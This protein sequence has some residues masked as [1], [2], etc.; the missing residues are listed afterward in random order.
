MQDT[1]NP[2]VRLKTTFGDM[3]ISLY[4]Q[5][6]PETVANFLRYVKEGFYDGTIFH[7]VIPG[8][9]N[10]GGGFKPGMKEKETFEA[11]RNEADNGLRNETGTIAMARTSEPHSATSQFFINA[12][13]ND[14]LDYKSPSE[15]GWGY[16]VFGKIIDGE[17]VH[18]AINKVSTGS[19]KGYDDVPVNDV[20]LE[21]AEVLD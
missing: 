11:I 21:K 13:N 3:T 17:S 20:I 1:K 19:S 15:S 7:R 9:M 16:C 4:K 10:Q 2:K 18:E 8:F 6:A 14:F 5:E 12:S